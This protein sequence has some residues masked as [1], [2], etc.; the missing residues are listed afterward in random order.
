MDS[1]LDVGRTLAFVD[2][3]HTMAATAL[4]G[5]TF[6]MGVLALPFEFELV[7]YHFMASYSLTFSLYIFTL[8]QLAD[9]TFSGAFV[10]SSL[11]AMSFNIAVLASMSIYRLFFHRC[12]KFPGPRLASLTRFYATYLAGKDVTFYK[13]IGKLHEQYGDFVRIGPREISVMRKE[14]VALVY[15]AG[16]ECRKSSWYGQIGNNPDKISINGVRDKEK[17]KLRRRAWDRALSKKSTYSPV[18]KKS[19]VSASLF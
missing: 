14:A 9:Y 1:L 18:T 12:G 15:G 2:T 16:S 3:A 8:I 13:E 6:H 7:M 4:Y 10:K 5:F 19:T 17:Y 11:A